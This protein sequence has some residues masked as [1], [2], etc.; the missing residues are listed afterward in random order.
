MQEL[1]HAK[2]EGETTYVAPSKAL[3][4]HGL[5]DQKGLYAGKRFSKN[6]CIGRFHGSVVARIQSAKEANDIVH[7]STMLVVMR[8]GTREPGFLVVDCADMK[9]PLLQFANDAR[10][11]GRRNNCRLTSH[12]RVIATRSIRPDE[13]L[14]FAYGKTYWK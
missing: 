11:T 12:G 4:E 2:K 14:L 10:G 7:E 1:R 3:A 8:A 13:E 5:G 6:E 9:S